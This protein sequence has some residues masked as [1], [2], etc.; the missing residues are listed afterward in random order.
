VHPSGRFLYASNRGHDSIAAFRIDQKNGH[1][2]ALGHTSTGGKTPR[3]FLIDPS[4]GLLYAAN[5]NSD[6]VI[7]LRIDEESGGLEPTGQVTEVPT[8]VC[9]KLLRLES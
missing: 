9:L 6:T 8:P 7:H 5:Q 3:Y 1:L 4:G 2:T